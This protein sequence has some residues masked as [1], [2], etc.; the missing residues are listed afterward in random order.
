MKRGRTNIIRKLR[1]VPFLVQVI[2]CHF[3]FAQKQRVQFAHLE[4]NRGLSHVDVLNVAQDRY[5]FMW[6]A[7]ANGL[8]KYDGNK[9]TVYK[10]D[11]AKSNS[12]AS[13]YVMGLIA[14]AEG[15][16]WVGSAA[17]LQKFD[18]HKE[19]FINYKFPVKNL[20]D[21]SDTGVFVI[22]EDRDH[23]LWI[24]SEANGLYFFD[25][26]NNRFIHY[27]F[28]AKDNSSL[29]NNSVRSIFEDSEHNFWI[30]TSNGLNLFDRQ[31]HSFTR[32]KHDEKDKGSLGHNMVNA[33]GEDSRH[34]LWVGT[35]GGG[36]DRYKKDAGTFTH[37]KNNPGS[38]NS[39][40]NDKVTVITADS[41]GNLW[42]GTE[43]DGLSI[44]DPLT[45]KFNN[46][47]HDDFDVRSLTDNSFNSIYKDSHDNMWV[48]TFAGGVNI[49]NKDG[50]MFTHYRH[51]PLKNS[52]S[53]NKVLTIYED[54]KDN[55]WIG[56][57]GGGLNLFDRRSGLFTLYK[58]DPA[59]QN[60]ICGNNVLDV[61]EDSQDN[62]WIASWGDGISVYNRS[63]NT[64]K[65]FKNQPSEPSGISTNFVRVLF[66]DSG[67][68]IWIGTSG[69]GLEM[70]DPKTNSFI[71][72]RHNNADSTTINSNYILCMFE[73]S[74]GTVWV[75]T[76]GGLNRFN[77]KDKIF[78]HVAHAVNVFSI[79]ESKDGNLW[80]GNEAGIFR[81][82]QHNNKI[83]NY[84]TK[85]GLADNSV[86][87]IL[88]D[89]KG[90]LWLSTV[91]GLSY[92][93]VST[94][95]FKNFSVEDGLQGNHFNENA[96][97]KS[98]NGK[99]YFGGVN[100]FNEF[101]PEGIKQNNFDLPLVLTGFQVFNKEA[102]I[103]VD[104]NDPSPL[105]QHISLT[106]EIDLPYSSSVIS[107]E[108]ASLNYTASQ[109]KQYAYMLE[110]FD[111]SWNYVGSKNNATYTNLD[112][113]RYVFKVKTTDNNGNWS[114]H[115]IAL[116]LTITPP[117]WLT[118]WFKTL[119]IVFVLGT[120]GVVYSIRVS[121]IR[122]RELV[123]KR[124]VAE[125]TYQLADAVEEEKRARQETD[126][127][128]RE[129]AKK[130]TELEQFAYIASHDLQEPLRTTSSFVEL[131]KDQYSGQM[132]AKADK[133]INY[134]LQAS[135]RMKVLIKDLLD[136]SR[137]GSKKELQKVDC[138]EK[139]EEVLA[140]LG[141]A[142]SEAGA[143]ITYT[144]LPVVS[145]YS[146]EIKQLFQNL[147]TNAIKFKKPGTIPE[148]DISAH[149]INGDWEFAFKDNGIGIDEKHSERIFV[150]FQRLHTRAE[151]EGSGIGLSH[152]KKIVELHN[153]KI[154]IKSVP[155]NGCTFHFTI[156]ASAAP[157]SVIIAHKEIQQNRIT[158]LYR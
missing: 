3:A 148:V 40:I 152:C 105:K 22:T 69:G 118:W 135:D 23:N 36:L 103:A 45:E 128:N 121:V 39:L 74:K 10:Y 109:K 58:H 150:I 12:I 142:I 158:S 20:P 151:Y 79:H 72:Y 18:R 50:G 124:L 48:G 21:A 47:L 146:T 19:K 155:G 83:L 130:N 131:L 147:V 24:G 90:N 136:Y 42:V 126:Y 29:S 2:L 110:G 34:R 64:Y 26:K 41:Q 46:Y 32:F 107:F 94:K 122:K 14:D 62:L 89:T 81:L 141:T 123:L 17:G 139:L 86:S 65:H 15:D 106:K 60:S 78:T 85:D 11:I 68:N 71:H 125:R 54:R 102:S 153:G 115:T 1:Y 49:W 8:N 149:K 96:Y 119:F 76:S 129:L 37:Y 137:I 77:K 38:K 67:K 116:R 93:N 108:F 61:L 59:N 101:S 88:E 4:A 134:I 5:G 113:D 127:A 35:Y 13:N 25:K 92:F 97:C 44:L 55:L 7:T 73:D 145:G 82:D 33:I 66:E 6:F 56:T 144:A 104:A 31:R 70:F 16:L 133:Y 117:F 30:G 156:P 111:K 154:W 120:L 91:N 43:N 99:M 63:T 27:Q 138:N 95:R 75:G 51:Q 114:E 140:D 100:G 9:F 57:D 98:R 53:N 132:D 52:L 157:V 84:T 28:D 87:G 143:K 80:F 112:P